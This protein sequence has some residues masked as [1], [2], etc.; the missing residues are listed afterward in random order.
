MNWQPIESAPKDGTRVI[1]TCAGYSHAPH[2]FSY[3]DAHQDVVHIA[4]FDGEYWRPFVPN[5]WTHWM[6]LPDPPK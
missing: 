4:R 3:P 1:L 6:P 5:N 2:P